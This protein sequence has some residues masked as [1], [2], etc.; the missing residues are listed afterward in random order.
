MSTRRGWLGKFDDGES[1][2]MLRLRRGDDDAR[3][4]EAMTMVRST[5]SGSA[6]NGL[7]VRPGVFGNGEIREGSLTS[8]RCGRKMKK[9]I[10]GCARA[11]E[12][13]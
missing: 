9:S 6:R 2:A 13:G 5:W 7:E 12:R 11:R 8:L 4:D 1:P 10:I 3:E